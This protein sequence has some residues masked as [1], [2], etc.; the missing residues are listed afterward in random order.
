MEHGKEKGLRGLGFVLFVYIASRLFYLLTGVLLARVMPVSRFAPTAIDDIEFGPL[1]IWAHFDGA[2]YSLIAANGYD[3]AGA[4]VFFPL[5]PLLMSSLATLFGGPLTL[6]ALS[7]W[8]VLVSLLAFPFALYFVYNIAHEGWGTRVA[9]VTVLTLALFPTAFFF[10]AAYTES[11]FLALSAGSLWALRVRRDLLLACLLAGLATATR[12]VGVFLLVPLAYEWLGN[13]R[14]FRWRG[15]YLALV[16][17]GL[18]AYAAYLWLRFGDPFLFYTEQRHWGRTT[19]DHLGT[20]LSAW[21]PALRGARMLLDSSLLADPS[22]SRLAAQVQSGNNTYYLIFFLFAVAL[23]V[24]GLRVLPYSLTGYALLLVL[25]PA[26]FG[27]PQSPLFSFPRFMLVAFPLF[28]T[29]AVVLEEH[30]W[31]LR[32]WL[33]LSATFSLVLCALFVSWRFVA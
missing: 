6:G 30:R 32:G 17:S 19:G 7:V 15:A 11:L 29:L 13:A 5:Y 26:L 3:I 12:N 2:W 14:E 8:G 27:P 25:V 24:A 18:L 1:N 16:P 21:K 4:P 9:K 20:L 23:L 22:L 28:I 33:V 31:L 10:N